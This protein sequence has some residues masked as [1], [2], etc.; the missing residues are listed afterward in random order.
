M[1]KTQDM[2]RNKQV[3]SRTEDSE[4]PNLYKNGDYVWLKSY[5]A[6]KGKCSKLQTKF[7]GPYLIT[8]ALPYHTYRLRR[9]DKETLQHEGRI[10]LHCSSERS[11][12]EILPR[13]GPRRPENF[14]KTNK[15][16][17]ETY[18]PQGEPFPPSSLHTGDPSLTYHDDGVLEITSLPNQSPRPLEVE[19]TTPQ[20]AIEAPNRTAYYDL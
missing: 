16:P 14:K 4:E 8:E 12:N 10:K 1:R 3:I 19:D 17:A 15:P 9:N 2:L 5:K 18:N 11:H 13:D 6:A 20:F 7:V